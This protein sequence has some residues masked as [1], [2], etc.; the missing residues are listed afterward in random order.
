MFVLF[1]T[2]GHIVF[3]YDAVTGEELLEQD[4]S[5]VLTDVNYQAENKRK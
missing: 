1:M 5:S 2:S 4:T 3:S